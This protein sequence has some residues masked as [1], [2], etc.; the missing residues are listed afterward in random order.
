M[1]HKIK[2][3]SFF[4]LMR[5]RNVQ[6]LGTNQESLQSSWRIPMCFMDPPFCL[7]GHV[8]TENA[9]W[10]LLTSKPSQTSSTAQKRKSDADTQEILGPKKRIVN[11]KWLEEFVWLVYDSNENTSTKICKTCLDACGHSAKPSQAFMHDTTNFLAQVLLTILITS[12]PCERGFSA[13]RKN[14]WSSKK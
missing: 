7:L 2:G 12:V 8:Y 3:R 10:H 13:Q 5:P 1:T 9:V 14:S 4:E 6:E 11:F